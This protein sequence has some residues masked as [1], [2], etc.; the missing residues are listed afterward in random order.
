MSENKDWYPLSDA[1]RRAISER[2]IGRA[3]IMLRSAG[4][5]HFWESEK[6]LE[7]TK[8]LWAALRRSICFGEALHNLGLHLWSDT[9]SFGYQKLC[10]ES[11]VD[12]V[13]E[14]EQLIREL[15]DI[16]AMSGK[17]LPFPVSQE[18]K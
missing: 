17:V 14:L 1:Q 12:E 2:I 10:L 11:Y 8:K 13:P 4:Y 9:F 6:D 16:R 18:G 3:F 15:D 5:G 7:D